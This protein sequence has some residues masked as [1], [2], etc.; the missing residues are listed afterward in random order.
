[1]T[2]VNY[3]GKNIDF[4]DI[5]YAYCKVKEGYRTKMYLDIKG[6][7][8]IGIGHLITGKEPWPITA[9]TV[10]TDAQVKQLFDSD[11]SALNVATYINEIQQ[12]GYSYNMMLAVGHFIWGH[13]EVPYKNSQ[14]RAGLVNKTLTKD[15]IHAYLL[16][17]WDKRSPT[18]QRV[19]KEDFTVGFDPTPW[20]PPFTFRP[21]SV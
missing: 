17:N 5:F 21:V 3:D 7:P 18:N 2:T 12:H 9:E 14:L 15:N 16:T 8:T 20:K 13:G 4:R 1:M 19:N 11:Y 6:K 10:L